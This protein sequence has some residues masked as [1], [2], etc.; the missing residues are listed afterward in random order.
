M[1]STV[2]W[3]NGLTEAT[4]IFLPTRDPEEETRPP[5]RTWLVCFLSRE[6]F[7]RAKDRQ[8]LISSH[9]AGGE[10]FTSCALLLR[11]F[12]SQVQPIRSR[13]GNHRNQGAAKPLLV[14]G[15]FKRLSQEEGGWKRRKE[16]RADLPADPSFA[17]TVGLQDAARRRDQLELCVRTTDSAAGAKA[18]R[19]SRLERGVCRGLKVKGESLCPSQS[20]LIF[21]PELVPGASAW[22]SW[23]C[24]RPWQDAILSTCNSSL[25]W[26]LKY[27]DPV[28]GGND[29]SMLETFQW[30]SQES[31]CSLFPNFLMRVMSPIILKWQ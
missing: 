16:R 21:L 6:H 1:G 7:P 24:P 13:A 31:A 22:S 10:G 23:W 2:R 18:A 14:I 30:R 17:R 19:E 26:P 4:C 3:V 5:E 11:T 8:A 25:G 15:R 20:F 27:P 28:L 12:S 9:F 29:F